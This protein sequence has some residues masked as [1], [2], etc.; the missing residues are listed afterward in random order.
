MS[1]LSSA[2]A[3]VARAPRPDPVAR[4]GVAPAAR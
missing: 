1:L 4:A 2:A 3:V